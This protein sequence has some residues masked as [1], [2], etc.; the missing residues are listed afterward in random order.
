[1]CGN[2]NGDDKQSELAYVHHK[3]AN[4]VINNLLKGT[5]RK[6]SMDQG[7]VK[8]VLMERTAKEAQ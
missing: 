3:E 1:M 2:K 7:I 8:L 4:Y 6:N 5:C